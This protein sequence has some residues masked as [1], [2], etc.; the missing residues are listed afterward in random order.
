[1]R[2]RRKEGNVLAV[3]KI[4]VPID[5]SETSNRAFHLACSLARDHGAQLVVL[6]VAAPLVSGYAGG[7]LLP[8]PEGYLDELRAKLSGLQARDPKVWVEHRLVEGDPASEILRVASEPRCDVIVMGTHGRTG[9]GR[10]L[11]G[12]VAEQVVRNAPCAVLTVKSPAPPTGE[13]ATG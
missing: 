8:P 5:Y 3:R 7:V 13:P 11:M 6:H 4:L 12:S 10:L 2:R 1:M 9:L